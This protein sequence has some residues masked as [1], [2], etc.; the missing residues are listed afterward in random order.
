MHL[1]ESL[2]TVIGAAATFIADASVSGN[3]C[4]SPRSAVMP[5]AFRDGERLRGRRL[6]NTG[7]RGAVECK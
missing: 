4:I 3:H 5:A 6:V 1:L 7:Y 2:P